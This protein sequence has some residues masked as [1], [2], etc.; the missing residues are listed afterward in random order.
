MSAGALPAA[1]NGRMDAKRLVLTAVA[2][3]AA[4]AAIGAA[5][6]PA[7]AAPRCE[8]SAHGELSHVERK[9][10]VTTYTYAVDVTTQEPCAR[11][12]VTL[13]STERISKTKVKTFTTKAEVELRDGSVSRVLNH[14]MPN[15][16]EMV[17]WE[18]KVT[19]CER[20]EP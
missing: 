19:G 3:I 9:E 17:R 1:Y 2:S 13:Y 14:D 15:G 5:A 4:L 18:V 8:A 20:C 12:G 7:P 16:H 11:V 10:T 6:A